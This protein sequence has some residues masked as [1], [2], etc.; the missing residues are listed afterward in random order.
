MPI[1]VGS[2]TGFND[3]ISVRVRPSACD[4]DEGRCAIMPNY[5]EKKYF[6]ESTSSGFDTLCNPGDVA[7][8]PGIY[9][10][11]CCGYE[12]VAKRGHLLPATENCPE[13]EPEWRCGAGIVRWRLVAAAIR[14]KK[15]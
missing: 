7:P 6:A 14:R 10:C 11:E 13:H 15:S 8:F 1:L 2:P 12:C 5:K 4:R 9:R 3:K